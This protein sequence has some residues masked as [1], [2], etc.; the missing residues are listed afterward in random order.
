MKIVSV[1][2]VIV[3]ISKGQAVYIVENIPTNHIVFKIT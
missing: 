1:V 2:D 3:T